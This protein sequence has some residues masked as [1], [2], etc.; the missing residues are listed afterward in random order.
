MTGMAANQGHAGNSPGTVVL[1]SLTFWSNDHASQFCAFIRRTV[2]SWAA[3]K[4]AGVAL[5]VTQISRLRIAGTM[6]WE[7]NRRS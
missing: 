7:Q 3:M 2:R 6:T 4:S 5:F 1:K